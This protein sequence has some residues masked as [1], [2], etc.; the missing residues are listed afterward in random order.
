MNDGDVLRIDFVNNATVSGGNNN[1]YDYTTHYNINDFQFGIV[2]VNGSPG[3]DAL[4]VWVKIYNANDDNPA[5]NTAAHSAAL[6]NGDT[7]INTITSILVNGVA[8]NL[9]TLVTD[10]NGGYLVTGLDLNDTVQVHASG[11]GYNRIEIENAINTPTLNNPSLNGE[12]FDIGAFSFVSTTTSIPSVGM[13][14][15]VALTDADGDK[16]ISDLSITLTAPGTQFNDWSASAVAVTSTVGDANNPQA[17]TKGSNFDDTLNGNSAA[18][19]LSGGLGN[20]TL[21]GNA[22]DD[23]LIGG[24]GSDKFVL[25]ATAALNGH[26]TI[27][28]LDASDSIIVDVASLNLTINTATLASFTTVTDANQ[29]TSWNGSSNQFLFNTSHN[30]LWYSANGT[31]AAAVDLAHVSTG[32]PAANAVH[33]M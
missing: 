14:Y 7:Q 21:Q 31:A 19:V 23:T 4:E 33:V 18:N 25:A 13:N 30:E 2:Q 29:A 9:A 20:D 10:G 26:D 1:T 5:G 17:N 15:D 32:V 28:D 8:V 3:A 11:N 16:S 22:G 27:A 6:V 12:A 24:A